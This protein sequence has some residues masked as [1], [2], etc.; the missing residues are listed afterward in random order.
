ML[1]RTEIIKNDKTDLENNPVEILTL[2]I[3]KPKLSSV[4]GFSRLDPAE[5]RIK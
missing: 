1:G 3:S 5:E 4:L 2:T